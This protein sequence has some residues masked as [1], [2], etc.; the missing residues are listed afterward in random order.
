SWVRRNKLD[1][2]LKSY[3]SYPMSVGIEDAKAIK[4]RAERLKRILSDPQLLDIICAHVANGGTIITLFRSYDVRYSDL[5]R[6]IHEERDREKAYIKALNDRGE[7]GMEIILRELRRIGLSDVRQMY[8]ED[9]SLKP[10]HE[11]PAELASV[12]SM[13]E[14]D[15]LFEGF[16]REREQVGYTKKVKLWDKMRALEML[17][18][19]LAMFTEKHEVIGK[20]S[21]EDVLD[22][23]WK[24]QDGEKT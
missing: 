23:V 13:I 14:S 4:E 12:V 10:P 22:R 5:T 6:W 7:W 21:L 24:K 9:G 17:G 8:R 18:K 16:G 19:N 2:S 20:L 1:L 15:E 3:L 11:W